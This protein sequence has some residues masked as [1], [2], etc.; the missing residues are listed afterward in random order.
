MPSIKVEQISGAAE[1]V[2]LAFEVA[3][4]GSRLANLARVGG[5]RVEEMDHFV[6]STTTPIVRLVPAGAPPP[7]DGRAAVLE[8]RKATPC[9]AASVA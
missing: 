3:A 1:S 9:P 5:Q 2:P 6:E 4:V 8:A 7:P